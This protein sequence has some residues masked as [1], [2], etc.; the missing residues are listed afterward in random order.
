MS[1]AYERETRFGVFGV[2][3]ART[4]LSDDIRRANLDDATGAEIFYRIPLAGDAVHLTP[5]I[6]HVENPGF[7]A[8]GATLDSQALVFGIRLCW[9]L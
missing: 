7:D 2:G 4:W 5:S 8:S 1:V 6:Q 9:I 3:I